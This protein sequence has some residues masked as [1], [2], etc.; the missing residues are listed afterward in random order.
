MV[1]FRSKDKMKEKTKIVA[2]PGPEVQQHN[3]SDTM[4]LSSQIIYWS[5]MLPNEEK[6]PLMA[7]KTELESKWR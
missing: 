1:A 6:G 5:S 3:Q 7:G 4:D 2:E